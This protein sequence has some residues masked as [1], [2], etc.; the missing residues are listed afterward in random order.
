MS[1]APG[2]LSV[3]CSERQPAQAARA[4]GS[5]TST[6]KSSALLPLRKT[7]TST[8]PRSATP[9]TSS[10][11]SASHAWHSRGS[12]SFTSRKRWLTLRTSTDR[13]RPSPC[14][15]ACPYPVMLRIFRPPLLSPVPYTCPL[16]LP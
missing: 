12:D 10:R 6:V 3:F 11:S 4:S 7:V 13:R 5:F 2:S 8:L 9:V 16:P 14:H 15:D 1:M